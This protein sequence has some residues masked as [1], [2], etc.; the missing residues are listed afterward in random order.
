[1]GYDLYITRA[2]SW[3]ESEGNPIRGE[4][5]LAVVEEDPELSVADNPSSPYFAVWSGESGHREPWLDWAQG[6][7]H[8]KNPDRPLIQKMASIAKRLGATVQGEEGEEYDGSEEG[9]QFD[10][11]DA[12]HVRPLPF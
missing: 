4:E 12:F 7:L 5:W 10:W 2:A 8:T 6:Y 11:R 3:A 1:M 9:Y